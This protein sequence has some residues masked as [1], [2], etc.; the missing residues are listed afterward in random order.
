[1]I[2]IIVPARNES[3]SIGSLI[4]KIKDSL[5]GAV[6]EI[7]VVDDGSED[8]TGESAK[9]IGTLIITHP[10]NLGKG[11][12]MKTG[13]NNATGEVIVFLDGD[14]AHDP[15]NISNVVKPIIN[16]EADLV[17]GSRNIRGAKVPT[18]PV[19]RNLANNYASFFIS[20]IISILIPLTQLPCRLFKQ[21]P[22]ISSGKMITRRSKPTRITDCTSGFRAISTDCW[23]Q[24]DLSSNGYQIE[25]EMIYEAAKRHFVI[26]EAPIRCNWNCEFSRLSIWNDGLSTLRLLA[27]K[28]IHDACHK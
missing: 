9:G 2:S 22:T 24:L 4:S 28:L 16:G 14:G 10:R 17:I 5:N 27:R 11:A 15:V 13:V 7:I 1:M 26:A 8:K 25:T 12:A 18:S 21:S 23:R 20:A 19:I 3:S 6:Y